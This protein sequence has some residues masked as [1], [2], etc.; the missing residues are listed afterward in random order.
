[1]NVEYQLLYSQRFRIQ[2][3]MKSSKK[4]VQEKPHH[5]ICVSFTTIT[6]RY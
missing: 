6:K 2:L 4:Q 1:M 5:N 3:Y